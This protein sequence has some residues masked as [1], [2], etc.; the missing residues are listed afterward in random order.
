MGKNLHFRHKG[1]NCLNYQIFSF[2]Q[3]ISIYKRP[4][5]PGFFFFFFKY[6]GKRD[7]SFYGFKLAFFEKQKNCKYFC[8]HNK[9]QQQSQNFH[10]QTF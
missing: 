9:T 10:K 2:Y 7:T 3:W 8:V 4:P 6:P 5:D 1:W